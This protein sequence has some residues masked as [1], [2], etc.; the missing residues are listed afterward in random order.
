LR[1]ALCPGSFDPVTCGHLDVIGRAARLVDRLYVTIFVNAEKSPLFTVQE[2]VE[3]L[4][5]ATA[6]I[7]HVAV[8]TWE[9]L[10]SEYVRRRDI[11][12]VVKGLRAV[13]DFEY[14]F[15]MAQMNMHLNAE[16]ETLFMMTRPA[17]A[18]LSSSI[19]KE[20]ARWGGDVAGLVT[21]G[22]ERRLRAKF[23][24]T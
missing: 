19:V 21:P 3:M 10:L 16:L 6:D 13:T 7:P 17:Y 22:V 14:E 15:Q 9:G 5:E 1:T 12:A 24:G 18:Y 23:G 2:R 20:V 11:Q 8:D 4:A